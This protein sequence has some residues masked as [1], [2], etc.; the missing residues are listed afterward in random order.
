MY[1]SISEESENKV[2]PYY[3]INTSPDILAKHMRFLYENK[4]SV[5][6]LKDVKRCFESGEKIN[7]KVVITFDD[8]FHDF[9]TKAFPI[10][11]K[12]GFTSTVFLPTGFI[13]NKKL[14]LKVKEHLHWNEVRELYKKGINF[15]SHTITHPQLKFL[16]KDEIEYEIRHSKEIIEDKLGEPIE[17]FSYPYKF[18]EEDRGFIRY[19]GDLLQECDYKYGVSTRIGTTSKKDDIF[20]MKRIPV[21]SY[22]DILLFKA[23]LEGGYDWLYF[24]QFFF[25][26]CKQSIKMYR[27]S[28][29]NDC[30]QF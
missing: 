20:F 17:S 5:I 2:S 12:Y 14:K 22:D 11:Q 25:K 27:R 30:K 3:R 16:K 23:K 26:S 10:L 13:D 8:G 18:P 24:P 28:K 1:H 4:Y 21:N 29:I 6:A 15:G 9:Y 19:L 7:N